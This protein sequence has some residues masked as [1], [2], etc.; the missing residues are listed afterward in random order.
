VSTPSFVLGDAIRSEIEGWKFLYVEEIC[1]PQVRIAVRVASV[2]CGGIDRHV[3]SRLCRICAVELQHARDAPKLRFHVRD[4]PV[5]DLEL[6]IG[7]DGSM[8]QV[9]IAVIS[10]VARYAHD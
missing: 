10:A 2:N 1:A 4:H 5:P 6:S 9:M 3:N 8:F 7:V